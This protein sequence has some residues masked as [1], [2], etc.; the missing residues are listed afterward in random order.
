MTPQQE[1]RIAEALRHVEMGFAVMSVWSTDP[2]GTC[3]CGKAHADKKSMG[4]HPIPPKGFLDASTDPKR[5]ETMLSA[6]SEPNYGIVWPEGAEDVVF[7]WDVDGE[8]W[9][10]RIRALKA[11]YG[12]LPA[13]KTT[14][15][16]SGGLHVFYKWPKGVPVPEGNHLHGFVVRWPWKGYVV[17]PG[18]R[19]NGKMYL[20]VGAKDIAELPLAW[21]V[22]EAVP[23]QSSVNIVVTEG[24]RL[25]ERVETGSR[26]DEIAKYVASRWNRGL[27]EAEMLGAVQTALSPLFA[28]PMD[29]DRLREEV[30]H[31]FTTAQ[32][33]W[34][35]PEGR[36]E[37][38]SG[39][40]PV[41]QATIGGRITVEVDLLEPET[42]IAPVAMRN[43][44]YSTSVQVAML[45]DHFRERTDASFEAL[46]ITSLTYLGALLGHTPSTFYGSREQHAAFFSM[47]VGMTGKSRKGTTVSLVSGALAQATDGVRGLK[48]SPNS[49]EGLI[50]LAA[51]A[52]GA[53]MLIL[54]EEFDRFL[55]SKGREGSTLSSILRQAFDDIP[56]T[57]A[58]AQKIVR[59][60]THHIAMLGNVT[61]EDIGDGMARIDLKNG[62]ANRIL[63]AGTFTRDQPVTVFDNAIDAPLRDSLREAIRWSNALT[64]PL[65]GGT[66]HQMEPAARQ[67]LT[68]AASRYTGGVGL[69]PF[70]SQRLDTIASRIALVY[71]CL[72]QSRV[73]EVIHVEA[74]LAVT[75]YAMASA[76][77]VFPETTG[78]IRADFV[79]RH[80]RVQGFLN[81]RELEALVSKR[82]LDVQQVVDLLALMGYA[83]RATRPRRDGK[84]GKA[85]SGIE[86]VS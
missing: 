51:K 31:A 78:D 86:I 71:A 30:H 14:R 44:A 83:R 6:A 84:P 55:T 3:R 28:D 36:A 63:W 13:T 9:Q 34:K 53:P 59:S 60:D 52:D 43:E 38:E 20:D 79:L 27:S 33:R 74:A 42:P 37:T 4:K 50:A 15:S 25:P 54:E 72:D 11:E 49:G 76:T 66:T 69:A 81:T 46:T 17:G 73:I 2:D 23:V 41:D 45:M 68:D 35:E 64:K 82:P 29:A 26:H 61:R 57:S 80:L 47:L 75:D 39:A 77:W 22:T 16:P 5:V 18:S 65:I 48:Q 1:E 62:F 19:I 8:D 32:K 10:T 21:A 67:M 40:N 7:E 24:Y 12:D 85:Q 70:L 58:T 56:L